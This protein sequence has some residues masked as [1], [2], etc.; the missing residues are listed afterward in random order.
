MIDYIKRFWAA[1]KTK[2]T[3]YVAVAATVVAI[4]PGAIN[5]S[6]SQLSDVIPHAYQHTL[7]AG[8]ALVTIWTRVRR[9][10]KP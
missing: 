2:V 7:L 1:A 10:L 5:D 6:W 3:T 4:L 9:E 8:L